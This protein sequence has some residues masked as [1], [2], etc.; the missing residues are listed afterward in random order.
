M[1]DKYSNA[2]DCYEL[3]KLLYEKLKYKIKITTSPYVGVVEGEYNCFNYSNYQ[4]HEDYL[5]DKVLFNYKYLKDEFLRISVGSENDNHS[6]GHKL[7]ILSDIY[8][9]LRKEFGEPTLFYT[10]KE[11]KEKALNLQWSF[12]NKKDDIDKFLN[13]KCFDDANVAKVVVINNNKNNAIGLPIELLDMVKENIDDYVIYKKGCL[14]LDKKNN[15]I[16][17]KRKL[18]KLN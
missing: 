14:E 15:E 12:K 3:T 2:N 13:N 17:Y 4:S 5:K 11:D 18:L 7:A 6:L 8:K 16:N 9:V 1:K 10:V